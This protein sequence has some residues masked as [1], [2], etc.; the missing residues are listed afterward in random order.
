MDLNRI[1]K[2]VGIKPEK[3]PEPEGIDPNPKR[4]V[5]QMRTFRWNLFELRK[6]HDGA[7]V[8]RGKS[9]LRF[10]NMQIRNDFIFKQSRLSAV[11]I[12]IYFR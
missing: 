2:V 6:K 5:I 8:V 4:K 10:F 9:G 7:N 1:W 3:D 12:V 11:F